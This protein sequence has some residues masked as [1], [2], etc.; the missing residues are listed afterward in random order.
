MDTISASAQA[1]SDIAS[2][3][4]NR[5]V[6]K[7]A[8]AL[9]ANSPFINIIEGGIMPDESDVVRSIVQQQAMPYDSL[10][11]PLFTDTFDVSGNIIEGSEQVGTTEYTYKLQTKRGRGPKIAVNKGRTSFEGSYLMAEDSL[12][13]LMV[14]YLNADIR[15]QLYRLSGA[16][17][18]CQ[19]GK[20]FADLYTGGDGEISVDFADMGDGLPNGIL[21]FK[22]LHK[23][24][25]WQKEAQFAECFEG[26]GQGQPH[27]RFI[28]SADI[29]ES[30]RAEIGVQNVLFALTQGSF[31][32]GETALTAYGFEQSPAYRGLAFGVDHRPL[33]YNVVDVDTNR[34]VLLNPVVASTTDGVTTAT[35]GVVARPN[36]AW[37]TAKYE[38]GFLCAKGSFS[39]LSPKRYVGEGSFKFAPQLHMG[40]LSWH[41]QLDNA[42]NEFG[43]FGH[44]KYEITR[45]FRPDRPQFILPIAYARV[46]EDT[47][48]IAFDVAEAV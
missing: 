38:I 9:A 5:I 2:K 22:T 8:E 36:P 35:N 37:L 12:K 31:K 45:A 3:D 48:V 15:N 21:T 6:G 10:A 4:T 24:A 43:D 17:F 44:H 18:L 47:G 34:P 29:I 40:E 41:Y 14:Q 39:R 16:K 28:G 26:G 42:E 23:L 20:E 33:R 27:M 30:F 1:I 7:I 32:L 19:T 25:R 13:K 11:E 46:P